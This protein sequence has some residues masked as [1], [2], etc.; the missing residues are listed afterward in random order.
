MKN[1]FTTLLVLVGLNLLFA[2]SS[3]AQV[4]F[5]QVSIKDTSY[6]ARI[7]ETATPRNFEVNIANG[8]WGPN[9]I[10]KYK[11]SE[12][13]NWSLISN[14]TIPSSD[15]YQYKAFKSFLYNGKPTVAYANNS[16]GIVIAQWNELS[17]QYLP[18]LP[19]LTSS[20]LGQ[21]DV[22]VNPITNQIYVS[23]E[24]VITSTSIYVYHYNGSNWILDL[25]L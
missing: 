6:C 22:S 14:N 8:S 1:Q 19:T 12:T 10:K 21:F 9:M 2:N 20:Y 15:I 23:C 5:V 17:N 25:N 24:Y 18:I 11:N 3:I 7:I 13:P 16:N 4:H